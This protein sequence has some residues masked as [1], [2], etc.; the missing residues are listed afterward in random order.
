MVGRTNATQLEWEAQAIP[1]TTFLESTPPGRMSPVE[2]VIEVDGPFLNVSTPDIR[3]F[4]DYPSCQCEQLFRYDGIRLP[5]SI[6]KKADYLLTYIC[7]ACGVSRR[8]IKVHIETHSL[9][10]I[11]KAMKY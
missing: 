11:Q 10:G 7:R 6:G 2:S 8:A 5:I 4:C 9:L 3:Q 1:W